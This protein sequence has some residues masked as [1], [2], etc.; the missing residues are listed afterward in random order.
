MIKRN[1]MLFFNILK[2]LRIIFMHITSVFR[3]YL[4]VFK[5]IKFTTLWPR[6]CPILQKRWP[7]VISSK[8]V[9]ADH[10]LKYLV[11]KKI[12][13]SI[14]VFHS[15][16]LMPLGFNVRYLF[17]KPLTPIKRCIFLLLILFTVNSIYSNNNYNI[18]NKF[19]NIIWILHPFKLKLNILQWLA[20]SQLGSQRWFFSNYN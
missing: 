20:L 19:Q 1:A 13:C 10:I 5:C 8:R 4:L 6:V 3:A 9:N 11:S 18:I 14:N 2:V 15:S 7:N 16:C 12:N 17:L